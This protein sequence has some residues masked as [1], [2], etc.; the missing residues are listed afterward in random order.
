M[1]NQKLVD[2]EINEKKAHTELMKA[3]AASIMA[4]IELVKANTRKAIAEA[5]KAEKN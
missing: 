1:S 2:A 3:N 4:S 5:K